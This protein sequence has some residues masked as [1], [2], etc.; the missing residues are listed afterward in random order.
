LSGR[1]SHLDTYRACATQAINWHIGDWWAFGDH[2]YGERAKITAEGLFGKEFGSLMNM[3]S[4]SRAF[5]PSRRGEVLSWTHDREAASLPANEADE[6][7]DR[8]EREGLST[9]ELRREVQALKAA[10]DP[11]ELSDR[12]PVEPREIAVDLICY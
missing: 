8:A 1:C 10:N 3:A 4:V 7:L 12:Q 6:L 9:R 2:R 5:E 11:G